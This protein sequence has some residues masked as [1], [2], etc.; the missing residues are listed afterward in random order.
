MKYKH[1]LNNDLRIAG[2][3][4]SDLTIHHAVRFLS[5]W[6]EG[7]RLSSLIM[8]YDEA[9]DFVV[10]NLDSKACESV[11]ELTEAYLKSNEEAREE[12][13]KGVTLKSLSKCLAV[14]DRCL[15]CRATGRRAMQLDQD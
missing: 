11:Q 7:A 2:I 5:Q 15:K 12:I 9:A 3:H 14:L 8:Y 1:I 13:T 10:L 6:E 4:I